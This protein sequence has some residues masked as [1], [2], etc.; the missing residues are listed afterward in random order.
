MRLLITAVAALIMLISPLANAE[1]DNFGRVM[2]IAFAEN[3]PPFSWKNLDGEVKGILPD[4]TREL[5][6]K[7]MGVKLDAIIFPWARGQLQVQEGAID[8]LFTIPTAAR[9]SYTEA[10][11]L[12]LFVSD[13]YLYTGR[14]NPHIALLRSMDSLQA[15]KENQMLGHAYILG[16]GWHEANLADVAKKEIVQDSKH[17]L[18]LLQHNRVDVYIEQR[19]LMNYQMKVLGFK[20]EIVE[21]PN[22]MGATN[23]HLMVGKNSPFKDDLPKL[24]KLIKDLTASGEMAKIREQIFSEYQ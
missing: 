18:K 1:A 22:S 3:Y 7:R 13:Y 16:G 15:L 9:L 4:F 11:E 8:A 10:T 21:V 20:D 24:N 2:T 14:N 19:A 23:W 6:E 12:P 5:L 17:I